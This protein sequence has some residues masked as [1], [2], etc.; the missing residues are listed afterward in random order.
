MHSQ[1][2]RQG[3]QHI[4]AQRLGVPVS[5]VGVRRCLARLPYFS[6]LLATFLSPIPAP[7]VTDDRQR[8]IEV[9]ATTAV[10]L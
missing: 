2:T 10:S 6:T 8:L 7:V 1:S 5:V 4:C 3:G 9:R